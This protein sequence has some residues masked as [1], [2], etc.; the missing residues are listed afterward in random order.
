VAV[1]QGIYAKALFDAAK[2][3]NSLGAVREQFADFVEAMNASPELRNLLRNPQIDMRAKQAGLEAVFGD[4]DEIFLNF[5]RL[6][7]EKGRLAQVD[8]IHREFERLVGCGEQVL[9][10]ELVTAYE[11]TNDEA[12]EIIGQIERAS[13]RR[14]EATRAVDPSLI[15]GIVLQAGSFRADASVRGRLN[16]LRHDLSTRS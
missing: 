11:L 10:V 8:E 13:G 7:A 15:G 6:A 12:N 9:E 3:K 4:A 5:L 16:S 2:E 14:V 1:A